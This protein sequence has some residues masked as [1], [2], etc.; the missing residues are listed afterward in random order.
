MAQ[1]DVVNVADEIEDEVDAR[2]PLD[3]LQIGFWGCLLFA[4]AAASTTLAWPQAGGP[5]GIIL[6]IAMAAGG[7]IFLLWILRGAGRRMGLFPERGA[8]ADAMKPATPKHSWIDALDEAVMIADRGGAPQAANA[9]YFELMSVA[10]MGQADASNPVSVD[11][12]FSAAPGLAAP[13]FRLSKAAKAGE[14]H[15]E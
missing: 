7:M 10:L 8:M 11:R 14:T 1:P 9:S 15:R 3:W 13:V 2:A 12:M 6:L 5:A 4:V